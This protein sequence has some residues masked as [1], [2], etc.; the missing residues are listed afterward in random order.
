MILT[1]NDLAARI[2]PAISAALEAKKTAILAAAPGG[3]ARMGIRAIWP[4]LQ[5]EVPNL[6]AVAVDAVRAEFGALSVADVLDWLGN[7]P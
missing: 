6:S 4:T 7:R 3:L 2:A 1:N 5:Q